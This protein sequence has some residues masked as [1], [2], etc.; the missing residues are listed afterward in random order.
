[1]T[2]V[3]IINVIHFREHCGFQIL[4]IFTE[5]FKFCLLKIDMRIILKDAFGPCAKEQ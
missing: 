1:M 3:T 4:A 2:K 5:L